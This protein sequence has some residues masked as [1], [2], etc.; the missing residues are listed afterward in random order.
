MKPYTLLSLLLLSALLSSCA[1]ITKTH[2]THPEGKTDADLH[3][4]WQD[5]MYQWSSLK[6]G[7]DTPYLIP[8]EHEG[9]LGM[10]MVNGD[11]DI[12]FEAECLEKKGWVYQE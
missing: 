7:S 8:E 5:C 10:M 2:W 9:P 3:K 4:D 1:Y 6:P 12:D 11:M